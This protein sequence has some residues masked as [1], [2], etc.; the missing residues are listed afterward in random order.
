[1]FPPLSLRIALTLLVADGV[2]ALYLGDLLG[3]AWAGA[4]GLALA[5]SWGV[6]WIRPRAG[7]PPLFGRLLVPLVAL[8]S[9]VDVLFLAATVLDGLARLLCFLV[10]YKLFTLRTVRDT[11]AIG[12]LAFFMLVAAAASAFGVG[13][14]FALVTFVALATWVAVVQQVLLAAE[15]APRRVVIGPLGSGRALSA[16][17]AVAALAALLVTAVLFFVIPRV[18]LAA[19]PLRARTG[20]MITGF[21]NRVELGAWGEI[22]TDDSVVM[23]VRVPDWVT[24]PD[25]L[26]G[27]RWRGVALDVY[28][29][30]AWMVG[31]PVRVPLPR[32]S[33][34]EF[35]VGIPRGTGRVLVQEIFLEPLGTDVV[36]AAP[37]VLHLRVRGASVQV[38]DMGGFAVPSPTAR[39]SY[40][41]YSELE[42]GLAGRPWARP[43][44]PLD[45]ATR[46]RYVQLPPL[47]PRV[48][49]LARAVAGESRDPHETARRLSAFLAR[50][51]RYTLALERQT[52]LDP[53]EE[54][55]FVS[56][57][58]N[59]EYFA[60]SLAVMLRSLG[61][62]ARVVNGFQR[63]EWNP[64]GRYFMVRLR[65]AHSWVEAYVGR[66][67]W[68]TLD[69]SPRVAAAPG[70][71]LGGV[72][73]YLDALRMRWHRYVI[74]WSLRDQIQAAVSLRHLA[75]RSGPW[76]AGTDLDGF[77]SPRALLAGV[78][79]AGALLAGWRW[80]H[81]LAPGRPAAAARP[82]RFYRRALR[83]LARRGLVPASS[84]T[85]REFAGRVAR[86]APPCGP[87]LVTLTAAYE[88]CRFGA[89]T[90][91]PP[92]VAELDACLV[93]LDRSPRRPE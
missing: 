34:N 76:G 41:V 11:R 61:I 88:R 20:A 60:A 46:A 83:R 29:G 84:E 58:G 7:V 8:A 57:S 70:G 5:A 22:E 42:E 30:R 6:A 28:D 10:L 1:M 49:D 92:D 39:L 64:Y 56:R 89:E 3:P 47:S 19:L 4:A 86:L 36:F 43:A 45:D 66:F 14:L 35:P 52:A 48:A 78:V 15:P 2:V 17:A 16:L 38:D 13:Y 71:N 82:P 44:P 21:S 33:G 25:G 55:L 63:G 18:G 65:H 59:C 77:T 79:L 26:P 53:V 23:R 51:F 54:F 90:L 50:S 93:A 67:G 91:T 37:R 80:R 69:P 73:L 87:P 32:V 68:V 85:A 12:F 27:V 24:D 40:T 31:R 9:A 74:N 62:P 75:A 81:R 72:G